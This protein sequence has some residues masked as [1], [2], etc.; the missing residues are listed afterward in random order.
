M[1]DASPQDTQGSAPAVLHTAKI[2]FQTLDYGD[3]KTGIVMQ[4]DSPEV[5]AALEEAKQGRGYD[6]PLVGLMGIIVQDMFNSAELL[7]RVSERWG[8]N[9]GNVEKTVDAQEGDR[10]PSEG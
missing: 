3:G 4:F 2:I 9:F 6:V 5:A 1:N 8:I 7:S 10:S